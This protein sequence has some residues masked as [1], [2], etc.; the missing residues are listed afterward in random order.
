[1][2]NPIGRPPYTEDQVA[3]MKELYLELIAQ[4]L[5]EH[6]INAVKNL[7]SWEIRR[8]WQSDPEFLAQLKEARKASAL[9]RM[10]DAEARLDHTYD[11]ALDDAASPQLVSAANNYAK[12]QH[13]IASKLDR[14]TWGEKQ[15]I[16]LG[17]QSDNPVKLDGKIE[18]VHVVPK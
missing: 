3:T 10:S 18:I 7:A 1:M 12:F 4:G 11:R 6:K 13:L 17:G 16:N 8:R 2:S 15:D 14:E 5:S 9:C